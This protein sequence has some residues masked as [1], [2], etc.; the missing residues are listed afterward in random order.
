MVLYVSKWNQY[1][2]FQEASMELNFIFLALG[3]LMTL[4]S[5]YS[6]LGNKRKGGQYMVLFLGAAATALMWIAVLYMF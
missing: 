2:D 5:W 4:W 3:L 1:N 6:V